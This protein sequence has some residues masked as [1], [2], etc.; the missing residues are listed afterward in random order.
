[1]TSVC[2]CVRAF[3]FVV[4]AVVVVFVLLIFTIELHVHV[5]TARN[6]VYKFHEIKFLR[7]FSIF[8]LIRADFKVKT[9]ARFG[10]CNEPQL[11]S[12]LPQ[13]SGTCV[14]VCIIRLPKCQLCIYDVDSLE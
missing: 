11:I 8:S 14:C 6:R 10:K 12:K 9:E 2:V 7:F 3:A 13:Q 1:M 5:Y 4:L